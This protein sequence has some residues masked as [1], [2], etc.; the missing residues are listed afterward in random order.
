MPLLSQKEYNRLKANL[1]RAQNTKDTKKVLEEC[2]RAF[3]IFDEQGY[4]DAWHRW[5]A[6]QRTAQMA[7]N[8]GIPYHP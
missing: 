4:P 5:E 7:I 3:T 6:A 8:Y 1:T 2:N